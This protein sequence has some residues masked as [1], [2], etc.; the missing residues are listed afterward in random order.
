[1]G[2]SPDSIVYCDCCDRRVLEVKCPFSCIDETFRCEESGEMIVC[3]NEQCKIGRFHLDCLRIEKVPRGK[4]FC[5]E[6]TNR[7]RGEKSRGK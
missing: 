5:P 7:K 2:A 3:G 4:W 6:C 1:M